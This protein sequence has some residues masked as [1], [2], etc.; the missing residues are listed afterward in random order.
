MRQGDEQ[1]I[2]GQDL[3]GIFSVR[4]SNEENQCKSWLT[5][6]KDGSLRKGRSKMGAQYGSLPRLA[7]IKAT[8]S[9][10]WGHPTFGPRVCALYN[11]LLQSSRTCQL[12]PVVHS[13]DG[14]ST[15]ADPIE[16]WRL[17][18]GNHKVENKRKREP[19]VEG[20]LTMRDQKADN[21]R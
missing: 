2:E 3:R 11:Q 4:F 7:L 18:R 9:S 16:I 19:V 13:Q 20:I 6:C 14:T 17:G 5:I 12:S 15:F 21:W 10:G 1:A 8:Q